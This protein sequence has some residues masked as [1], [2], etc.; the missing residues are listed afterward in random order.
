MEEWKEYKLGDVIKLSS[1]GT[2]NKSN[3][4]YWDGDIP[5]I[6][7]KSMYDDYL[8]SSDVSITNEGLNNGSKL[9]P[10]NSIL[11][12]TRGSGLFNRIP[13]CL[14][15]KEMAFNQDVKCIESSNQDIVSNL[16]LFYWLMGNKLEISNI[17]ET[18]GIGAGKIDTERFKNITI[19]LPPIESQRILINFAESIM[20]KIELNRRINANLEAQAQALFKSWFVDFEPFR[21]GEFVESELG[22]IPKGWR[23]GTLGEVGEI[24]GGSTPSKARPDYYTNN[25]ISWLTPKDL[26]VS[27]CK[28]TAK[29][30]TDITQEGYDSC[31]T[32]LMPKGSVLFS[33]RAPIGYITIAKNEICTNQGFKSVIPKIAGTAFLYYFLKMSTKEIENKATGST[34]KEASGSLMK[35]LPLVIAPN[36]IMDGFEES[37]EPILNQQEILED[38]SSRLATLRDTLLPRLMSGELKV[39]ELNN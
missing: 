23:V 1:G 9:A 20:L 3:A 22:M 24:V 4:S 10:I 19:Q 34:F 16:F 38:E 33:S 36:E 11:L 35:S 29:G 7:A 28:F 6:S 13:V 14:V 2:P 31:S 27:N 21:D 39:N 30:E 12:L 25:G 37:V 26:S 32:K 17:L 18:T 5:W 15:K 8:Y